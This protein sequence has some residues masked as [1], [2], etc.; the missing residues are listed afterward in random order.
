[1]KII[2]DLAD[3]AVKNNKKDTL[4]IKISILLAVMIL[5]SIIF[6]FD[7]LRSD[8]YNYIKNTFGDYHVAITEIDEKFYDEL[9]SD[10]DIEKISF[11]KVIKTDLKASIYETGDKNALLA[12]EI[13][14]GRRPENT[15]ELLVPEKFL[16]KNREYN[17]DSKIKIKGKTYTIVG[18]Y[19]D[20]GYSFEES[21]ILGLASSDKKEDLYKDYSGIEAQ[22]WFKNIRDTYTKTREIL[23]KMNIDEKD[24]LDI[25]R[26]FYNKD[27]LEYKMVYP[28]GVI[29][30]KNVIN[31]AI[32]K[33]GIAFLF[34]M[35]FAFII[36][37][38][39][40]VWNNRDLCEIALLKSVGMTKRQ[41][42]KMVR[43]KA[44]KLSTL[45]IALGT[46]L[47]WA[48][49][50][51]LMYLMWLNNSISYKNISKI[52]GEILKSPEFNFL[53]PRIGSII[54]IILLSLLMV[55]FSAKIP[56]KRSS[57]LKII[58]GLSGIT[59]KNIKL[60]KSKIKGPIEKTLAKDY[61]RSYRSTYRII[62]FSMTLSAFVLTAILVSQSYRVLN[63]KYDNYKS[64]YNF[65]SSIY[66][67]T[68][69]NENFFKDMEKVEGV[70]QFHIYQ[71]NDTK[72][73]VDENKDFISKDLKK[74]L[75][76]GK[77]VKDKL[78]TS[79]YALTDE[80]FDKLLKENNISKA[81]YLLLNKI[82]K[83]NNT[84]YTFREYIK[85]S[86]KKAS[87]I[88]LKYNKNAN[89]M[90]VKIDGV[91]D[92][93]PYDL[94]AYSNN[95][96]AIFTSKSNLKEFIDKYGIDKSNPVYYYFVR[97]K[98]EKNKDKVFEEAENVISTYSS[99]SDHG[100]TTDIIRAA[101]DKEERRNTGLM[102]LA[103][104][105]ILITIALSNAYNSFKGNL[106]AR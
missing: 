41:V 19:D 9:K 33:Y 54:I 68:F 4:A 32:E 89:P 105:I 6:I 96:I 40:N 81:S 75:D 12:Y 53:F 20:F 76:S 3:A 5:G 60:G 14:K 29:P 69:L 95:E 38:A 50:N 13:K 99:K 26:V 88:S 103:I 77:K 37:G 21:L 39:F 86:D 23:S 85:I 15:N 100:T 63:E 47:S 92:E 67:D 43:L 58:E 31:S 25:G 34:C 84:P 36:Y 82:A 49:A 74:S 44:L 90:L 48:F 18:I 45:P 62:V 73:Y 22:I 70:D 93:M 35:I 87:E 97:M 59:E 42:K 27:I 71:R 106:R 11:N 94:E 17:L 24:A 55:Y 80:D 61:Y 56:A 52:L 28:G 57:K 16:I 65:R 30:P 98:V 102:N 78:Y 91:I 46:I 83:D 72:F 7:T 104:Q 1:M 51:L 66:A 2:N 8:Q 10:K 101:M 79:I 64:P